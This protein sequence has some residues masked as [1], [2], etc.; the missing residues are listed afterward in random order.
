MPISG[1]RLGGSSAVRNAS[2]LNGSV[3]VRH[4]DSHLLPVSHYA[5]SNALLVITLIF[6]NFRGK[7]KVVPVPN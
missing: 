1:S 4:T 3:N 5:L 2:R 7:G 6:T